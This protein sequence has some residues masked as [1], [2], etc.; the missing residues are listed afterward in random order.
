MLTANCQLPTD[1]S[2]FVFIF[3]FC[4]ILICTNF[5]LRRGYEKNRTGNS[6]FIA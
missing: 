3:A 4:R 6:G 1:N 2:A 5:V